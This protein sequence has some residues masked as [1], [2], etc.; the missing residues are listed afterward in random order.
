VFYPVTLKVIS[1]VATWI[2]TGSAIVLFL[3]ALVQSFRRIRR[4]RGTRKKSEAAVND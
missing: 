4:T 2:T 1:P 3:S